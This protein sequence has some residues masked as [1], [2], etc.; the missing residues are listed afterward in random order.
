MRF[1]S[2]FSTF[3]KKRFHA[4]GL[5]IGGLFF[6]FLPLFAQA[7]TISPPR[8]E[9]S[10][11]PG[12]TV[13]SELKVSNDST[14]SQTY[15]TQ[16]ENFEAKDETGDPE[17]VQTKEGLSVWTNV[18]PSIVIPANGQA[19]IPFT[20]K[21][22][23]NA[24]PGGYFASIFVRTTPPPT[25]SG[26]VSIGARL[27]TLVLFRVNGDIQE[28]V[29]ILEYGTKNFQHFFTSLPIDFYYRFQNTGDDRVKPIG[30]IIIKNIFGLKA[31]IL[32][33][34]PTGGSV[35]PRS[36]RR[37]ESA[38]TNGG[39]GQ[40]DSSTVFTPHTAGSFLDEAKYEWHNF[41]FGMYTAHLNI[42]YGQNNTP[43]SGKFRFFV[44]PWQLLTI[45]V[46]GLVILLIILRFLIKRYNRYIVAQ[47]QQNKN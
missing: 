43:A 21:V 40:Q 47:H 38:W 45:F 1:S 14:S 5:A 29:D 27:G 19:S 6:F 16:V 30:D 24:E 2:L 10:G 17:F 28:G 15:Y 26:E 41:A 35:L 33:A 39:G 36:I 18:Q 31:K 46:V 34:N 8:I 20:I 9:L 42:A 44:F 23:A 13:T 7:I 32:D 12:S 25:G 37:F 3:Y 22:P 4:I 11:D